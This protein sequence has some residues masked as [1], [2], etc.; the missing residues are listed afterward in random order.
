MVRVKSWSILVHIGHI[1]FTKSLTG[2]TSVACFHLEQYVL[3]ANMALYINENHI[4]FDHIDAYH[5]CMRGHSYF[6]WIRAAVIFPSFINLSSACI[7]FD[8]NFSWGSWNIL[9]T[10][11]HGEHVFLV[12]VLWWWLIWHILSSWL[13]IP[14]SNFYIMLCYHG[15]LVRHLSFFCDTC[16]LQLIFVILCFM[17]FCLL[18]ADNIHN[19][20]QSVGVLPDFD[21][22]C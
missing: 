19:S 3:A 9:T 1:I 11:P 7:H 10:N 17:Y 8:L 14:H 5:S 12:T 21:Y 22:A 15:S 6:A 2:L 20:L 13:H 4:V 18:L 16:M